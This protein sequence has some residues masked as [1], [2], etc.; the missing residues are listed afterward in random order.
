MKPMKTFNLDD[1]VD[2]KFKGVDFDISPKC[3]RQITTKPSCNLKT[4]HQNDFNEFFGIWNESD[5]KNFKV[6]TSNIRRV[7]PE[8]WK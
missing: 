3:I 2:S 7:D 6:R 8:D 1:N 5:L 4:I